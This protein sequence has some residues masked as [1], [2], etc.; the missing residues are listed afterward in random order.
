MVGSPW[1]FGG[2]YSTADVWERPLAA[3]LSRLRNARS[4][5]DAAPTEQAKF[6]A[7]KEGTGVSG[8]L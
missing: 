7:K 3:I 6:Q 5:R 2:E 4:R 1:E 8:A